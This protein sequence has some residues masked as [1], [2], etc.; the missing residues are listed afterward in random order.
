[1][2]GLPAR[3][4]RP[5][6]HM[7]SK[8][9]VRNPWGWHSRPP[10]SSPSFLTLAKALELT[11]VGSW[12][13]VGNAWA[14]DLSGGHKIRVA[15]PA[16]AARI[17]AAGGVLIADYGSYRLYRTAQ[18]A[19]DWSATARAE[20]R[21]DYNVIFLNAAELNTTQA[22]A[23][24]QRQSAKTTATFSGR[25]LHLVQFAGPILPAW[26]AELLATG[27]R[28]VDYI[29][30]NAYLIYGDA[31][32]LAQTRK[33]AAT[34]P[35]IQ[36]EGDYLADYV[37]HPDARLV[38]ASGNPRPI[39]TDR[40][41]IQLVADGE[42]NAATLA[43]LDQ[44]Q[45]EPRQ[46]RASTTNYVNVVAR[47]DATKLDQIAAQPDVISIQPYFKPR[48]LC[49]RQAQI[50]AGNLSGNV[51]SGAGYLAWLASKGFTAE[52]FAE[53]GFV[54]DVADSGIDNG[55]ITPNHFAL[56]A[57][58]DLTKESRVAYSYLA[59][60]PN[61]THTYVT[62]ENKKPSSSTL[63]GWDGHGN[64]NAH[65]IAGYDAQK[66]AYHVDSAGYQYGLGVCPF[67]KVGASVVFDPDYFTDPNYSDML[68]L[69]YDSGARISNNSWGSAND[70]KYD[71][72]A[73]AYDA[74]SRDVG[75]TLENRA[76]VLVFVS[77]N[78]GP[79]AKTVNSPGT[80]K[81]VI[82]V[83]ASENVRSISP[84][85]GGTSSSGYDGSGVTDS[86]ANNA[87]DLADFSS[88]GPCSD[89]R[90]KPDLVAPGSHITG[91]VP[92]ASPAPD[93]AGTGSALAC[94]DATGVSALQ[95]DN[96]FPLNQEFFTVSSGTSH[97]GPAVAGACAL[98]RQY[99]LNQGWGA[100][101]PAMTKAFLMNS[102]R[103]LTG[104]YAGDSLWSN[105]QGMGAVNLGTA[106]DGLPRLVRDQTAADV[107]TASG[108]IRTFTSTVADTSKPVRVTLVW[109]DAP[110]STTGAAYN[111]DLDLTVTVG[112]N[113][114]QG[115][116]FSGAYSI[117]G[118]TADGKNNVESVFLP[119]GVSGQIIVNIVSANI[120]SPGLPNAA[121]APAQD[122][123]LV[124]Y[125]AGSVPVAAPTIA[126]INAAGGTVSITFAGTANVKYT[127]EYKAD[128]TS[129]SWT[130]AAT[131]TPATNG[132]I[133]LQDAS[134]AA[135]SRFY[136]VRA[137]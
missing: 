135:T 107:F 125:N 56:Y 63:E 104:A 93:P 24:M 72:D 4:L 88:R 97:A 86:D 16:I 48:K 102:T 78:E 92:Q 74:L 35:H 9:N 64:I 3:N 127:L 14:A 62:C 49:E 7:M 8:P 121:N 19:A 26:R 87:A 28:I 29:P 84:A 30:Q 123:A 101:S 10:R 114:Y 131:S 79:D 65:I 27:A 106:F 50:M 5:M 43:L 124:A 6:E 91:G 66:L 112:G 82:T 2:L 130:A 31:P 51:P 90:K 103:Y 115:N 137:E 44:L 100:P 22:S 95:A 69:A 11:L 71:I 110:G 77:G 1:M 134:G 52:Q 83:G 23:Q 36:W 39:G 119:A 57:Q 47:V 41:A 33:M 46:P 108:Q 38:D 109:S 34:A 32:S 67:V 20:V 113:S 133:T 89:G 128:L 116:V 25:R 132:E 111:N 68:T 105:G 17:E 55:T 122:F 53:S 76:V 118:G 136:R 15:D 94:F 81:N 45:L 42:A 80:A 12:L 40:Y 126:N 120:A 99:F 117:T 96:F 129:E 21:D 59:G 60:T 61:G 13:A 70:G 73:Q 58:G 18:M 98:V 75:G 85:N 37:V 54:V